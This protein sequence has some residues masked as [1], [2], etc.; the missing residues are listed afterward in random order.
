MD[1]ATAR[2][3]VLDAA[4]ELFYERGIQVVSMDALRAASG[5]SLKRLYH[6]FPSKEA[7]V[8]EVLHASHDM[9]TSWLDAATS[10]AGDPRERLLTVYDMLA[11]WFDQDG[12]RGCIFIN[13]FGELGAVS[14]GVAEIVRTHKADFQ[15]TVDTLVTRAGAPPELGPQLA[16]LAEGAQT[17]AAIA[18]TGE[19]AGHARHA[20]EVLV[21]DALRRSS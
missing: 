19:A 17:T 15:A 5:V 8:Q 11:R 7:I 21:D 9:W 4:N 1:D 12:F 3:R 18:G 14:P 6:L 20:A 10:G 13:S 16:I 2:S